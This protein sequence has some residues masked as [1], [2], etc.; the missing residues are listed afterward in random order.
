[1]RRRHFIQAVASAAIAWPFAARAQQSRVQKIG[2]LYPGNATASVSRIAAFREGLRSA[3][4][5]DDQIE[6][7]ARSADGDPK[8]IASMAAELINLKVDVLIPTSPIA[9]QAVRDSMIPIVAFDLETDPVGSGL[10]ASL[11]HP[12]GNVTGVFFDF[13][14]FTMK[15]MEL[16][17]EAIPQLA[18]VVVLW[19]PATGAVQKTAVE[20]AA[21]ILRIQLS[22]IEVRAAADLDGAFAAAAQRAPDALL[23]LSSPLFGTNPK[24]TADFT[25]RY[26]LPAVTL[27]PDVAR[28]GVLMAYGANLFDAFRQCG[29]LAA[30]VLRGAKPADLPIELPAKFELVVN[31]KTAKILGITL[32]SG[33][34]LRADEV[35]E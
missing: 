21:G 4:F 12:G 25:L 17:K 8:R 18:N 31:L 24:R 13:P 20:T 35:I 6:L 33:V 1:M 16:L 2:F 5:R 14:S 19:D 22:I 10:V 26:K 28:A 11:S 15:W 34:L 7:I 3:G 27:F 32:P 9:V 23:M 29:V 30:K